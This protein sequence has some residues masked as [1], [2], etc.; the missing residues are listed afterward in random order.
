MG[1]DERDH[2]SN[3]EIKWTLNVRK[4]MFIAALICVVP[5]VAVSP[6]RRAVRDILN[7]PDSAKLNA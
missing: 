2:S 3:R 7:D 6:K 4:G 5:C 1:S